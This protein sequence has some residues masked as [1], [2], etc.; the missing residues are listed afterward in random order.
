MGYPVVLKSGKNYI[1]LVLDA[2]LE[3]SELLKKIVEKFKETERFFSDHAIALMFSGRELTDLQE[4]QVLEAIRRHT[5]VQVSFVV[6]NDEFRSYAAERKAYDLMYPADREDEYGMMVPVEAELNAIII[7]RD[8]RK[9]QTIQAIG[10]LILNGHVEEGATVKA[11]GSVIILGRAEGQIIAGTDINAKDPFIFALQ[12]A[13]TNYRIG[14]YVGT[15]RPKGKKGFFGGRRQLPC[16]V[17]LL[18][19]ELVIDEFND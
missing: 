5:T 7:D 12:F 8:V 9:G 2:D 4:K 6:E 10:G 3:F 19:D 17:T 1:T 11:G 16:L 14:P 15:R 13:P 18:D